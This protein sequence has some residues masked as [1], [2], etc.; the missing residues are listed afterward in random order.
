MRCVCF[1]RARYGITEKSR[2]QHLMQ[3]HEELVLLRASPSKAILLTGADIH[4]RRCHCHLGGHAARERQC[5]KDAG[6]EP[7]GNWQPLMLDPA[8]PV[9]ACLQ[10]YEWK[11][12]EPSSA[13]AFFPCA[14]TTSILMADGLYKGCRD[15]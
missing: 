5:R 10:S 13:F 1:A 11:S 3:D 12:S 4:A 15:D 2:Y 14:V 7:E 6:K 9:V 8:G